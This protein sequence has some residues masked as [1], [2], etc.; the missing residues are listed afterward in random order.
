MCHCIVHP[1]G[2]AQFALA[3][4]PRPLLVAGDRALPIE[5]DARGPILGLLDHVDWP[6]TEVQ[7][8][9][10]GMLV[11]YTDGL[12]EARRDGDIFGWARAAEVLTSCP[13]QSLEERIAYLTESA[14][15][16]DEGHLRDDVA[17]LAV[18]RVG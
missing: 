11:I 17:V 4:H 1:D 9:V 18:Q 15:R 14:R 10:G 12:V 5:V 13:R 8:P 7:I 2:R 3:G 6:V 16:Y